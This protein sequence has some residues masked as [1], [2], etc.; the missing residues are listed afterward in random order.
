MTDFNTMQLIK[1]RFFAM[2]NGVIADVL[3]RNGSPFRIIFG[4]VLPQ[5]DEI[6]RDFG[7]NHEIA[8]LLWDNAT[9]RESM[10]LAPMMMEQDRLS[11]ADAI[12]LVKTSPSAETTDQL[13]HKLLRHRTD[14]LQL[15]MQLSESEIS[16]C[17][18]AAMRML[19]H[20]V[21]TDD[22]LTAKA[23]ATKELERNDR[24][25]IGPARQIVEEIEESD[26]A[27]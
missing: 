6:A 10:L 7:Q 19:W 13:V 23:L 16:M 9:T 11:D 21:Y 22:R 5:I 17:R 25:T 2:R 18:Y 4:L 27:S 1:R 14:S 8:L 12:N 15:A 3:R 26:P 24:L 20:F